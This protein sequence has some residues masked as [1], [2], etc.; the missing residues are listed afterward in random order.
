MRR[1]RAPRP[2]ATRKPGGYEVKDPGD[3][4]QMDT[5]QVTLGPGLAYKHFTLRDMV[6]RWD[7]VEVF[8][9]A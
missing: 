9:R 5:V 4:V 2:Y 3:L 1:S 6:S 7:A 8:S